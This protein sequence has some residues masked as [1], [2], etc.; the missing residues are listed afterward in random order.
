M[1]RLLVCALTAGPMLAPALAFA[2]SPPWLAASLGGRHRHDDFWEDR[3]Q[4]MRKIW[5]TPYVPL[6][7]Y[8][9]QVIGLPPQAAPVAPGVY[10]DQ[11][12]HRRGFQR[13]HRGSSPAVPP[14][15]EYSPG[16]VPPPPACVPGH[17]T[18]PGG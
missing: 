12:I 6:G 5:G 1:N 3:Y 13:G 14:V 11:P 7:Y 10:A 18:H 4:A 9:N 2:G 17:F 15:V 16:H 8:W